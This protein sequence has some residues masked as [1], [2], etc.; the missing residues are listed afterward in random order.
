MKVVIFSQF[1]PPEM[2]PSGFMFGSLAKFLAKSE[3]VDQ[4]DVIC[5]FANFPKG[6]FIDRKWY[7]LFKTS[8][9]DG[10]NIHNVIVVPS[11]NKSNIK[12]IL[13]YTS[14]LFTAILKG[15]FMRAPDVIVATSP[16]IFAALAGLV[17]A[18]L[19]G[20]K[21]VLDVRDIWPE[22]AV[23]MGSVR[24]KKIIALLEWIELL[25]YKNASLITVATPGMVDMVQ[26]KIG[27]LKTPIQYIPCGVMIPHED[28]LK[29]EGG[30]PFQ[31]SDHDK[32][33]V[34]YAGL[35]GHAQNLATLVD[36][37]AILKHRDDI[38]FYF[39]GA[40]PDKDRVVEHATSLELPNVKFLP[41]VTRDEI[42]RFFV[43]AGCAIVPLQDL[44]IFKNV[45][46]SKTFE[47]MS[48]GVPTVVGVGGEIGK[49]IQST[50][51]GQSVKPESAEEYSNAIVRYAD[52]EKYRCQVSIKAIETAKNSFDYEVVNKEFEELLIA[53]RN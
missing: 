45:F 49:L 17:V 10:V 32:F 38:V 28:E 8:R 11:D 50:D 39:I 25:L 27:T 34:L 18:K 5:G 43:F 7:S 51:A 6:K 20:A 53:L 24:N 35:H 22:S 41:P 21:F 42:R 19:K 2:E 48:Y 16:P 3:S 47:L 29:K 33:C 13:N 44:D 37:A 26:A 52:D 9:Q 1:F 14:Y 30:S 36:A 12:R 31:E 46:P 40:G 15:V 23:Q 4:V